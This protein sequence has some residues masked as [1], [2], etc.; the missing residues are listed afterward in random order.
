M[1]QLPLASNRIKIQF[2][3]PNLEKARKKFKKL[4]R[5]SVT[6]RLLP[7]NTG[8][9]INILGQ[10]YPNLSFPISVRC[11]YAI[12]PAIKAL[13][14]Y[15]NRT[16]KAENKIWATRV[17]LEIQESSDSDEI[18]IYFRAALIPNICT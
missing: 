18:L 12:F 17:K 16:S 5:G 10:E 6:N 14:K 13:A 11:K 15:L 1:C 2:P 9:T 4:T 3:E 7:V 8:P